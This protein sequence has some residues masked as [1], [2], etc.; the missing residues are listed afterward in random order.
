ML[1]LKLLNTLK[2]RDEERDLAFHEETKN[3]PHNTVYINKKKIYKYIYKYRHSMVS[4]KLGH[5]FPMWC[6][7]ARVRDLELCSVKCNISVLLPPG[8]T[9]E[10][11]SKDAE[12]RC[13]YSSLLCHYF[14]FLYRYLPGD[15]FYRQDE[16][17]SL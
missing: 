8:R 11:G 10:F 15:A 14:T 16:W 2:K 17:G 6:V 1:Q 5:H 12:K 4:S 7:R 13:D 3:S 9:D